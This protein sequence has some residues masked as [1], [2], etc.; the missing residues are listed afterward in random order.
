MYFN[1]TNTQSNIFKNFLHGHAVEACKFL[2][3]STVFMFLNI[4]LLLVIFD[5]SSIGEPPKES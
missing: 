3:L 2:P 1:A 4:K 5:T